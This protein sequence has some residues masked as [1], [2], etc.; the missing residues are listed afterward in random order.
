MTSEIS[1]PPPFPNAF[2][3]PVNSWT[4]GNVDTCF[5]LTTIYKRSSRTYFLPWK[6]CRWLLRSAFFDT[7]RRAQLLMRWSRRALC[8]ETHNEKTMSLLWNEYPI[9]RKFAGGLFCNKK[10]NQVLLGE[11]RAMWSVRQG[12]VQWPVLPVPPNCR[13]NVD[14]VPTS[15]DIRVLHLL[16]IL[17]DRKDDNDL[18]TVALLTPQADN[19]SH[20]HY[21]WYWQRKFV[22]D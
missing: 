4:R 5:F 13:L 21:L 20:I 8:N 12:F 19:L 14:R 15:N 6:I 22:Y 10:Y 16:M 2:W 17:T 18:L 1:P 11:A 3:E 9:F 7:T